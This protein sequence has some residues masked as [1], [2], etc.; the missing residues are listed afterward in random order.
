[1][2]S[3]Y[4]QNPTESGHYE[5]PEHAFIIWNS[6]PKALLGGTEIRHENVAAVSEIKRGLMAA[7][8]LPKAQLTKRNDYLPNTTEK[9][10][11]LSIEFFDPSQNF[12]IRIR[13]VIWASR[14]TFG[15][16]R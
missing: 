14:V 10:K 11:T 12:R 2:K 13:T 9:H 3:K 6:G 15:T 4:S 8:M 7:Q 1:M 5:K 16:L